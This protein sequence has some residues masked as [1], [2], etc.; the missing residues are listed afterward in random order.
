MAERNSDDT[1]TIDPN[2][3]FCS[4]TK[5]FHSTRP[6][7]LLPPESKQLSIADFIFSKLQTSSASLENTVA[8]IDAATGRHISYSEFKCRTETLAA[9]LQNR[10]GLSRGDSA[11]ILSP[12]SLHVPVLYFSL[13]SIGVII[14]PSNP[15][16]KESEISRQIELCKPVIAFATSTS[17]H[18]IPS[19]RHRTVILDS[20]EFLSMMTI[21]SGEYRKVQVSQSDPATILYSSGI[22]VFNLPRGS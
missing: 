15:A 17:A 21:R 6:S 22:L 16:S 12:N 3:G 20:Q 1:S 2:S 4:K 14:S 13:L 8:L 9:S 19:L 11:F 5:I 10:I 7:V 18:K